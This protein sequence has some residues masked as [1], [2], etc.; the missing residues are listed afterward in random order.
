MKQG[1]AAEAVR[2]YQ[3]ALRL[4]PGDAKIKAKLQALGA[5][6]SN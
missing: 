3:E 5:P 4:N 2:Y 6:V 1:Q